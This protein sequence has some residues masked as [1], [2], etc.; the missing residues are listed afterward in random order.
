[1]SWVLLA[2]HVFMGRVSD[3]I[4]ASAHVGIEGDVKKATEGPRRGAGAANAW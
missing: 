3:M 1:M 4:D 2:A